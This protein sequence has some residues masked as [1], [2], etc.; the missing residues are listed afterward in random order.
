MLN[1]L[2]SNLSSI[3]ADNPSRK[4]LS[5][6]CPSDVAEAGA[7]SGSAITGGR[8]APG[9]PYESGDCVDRPCSAS[10]TADGCQGDLNKAVSLALLKEDGK[11]A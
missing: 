7:A 11:A 9:E 10:S 5:V 6:E 3:S 1:R 8:N 4:S 2:L